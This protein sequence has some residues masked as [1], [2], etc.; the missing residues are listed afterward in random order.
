MRTGASLRRFQAM[1]AF[2]SLLAI[3]PDEARAESDDTA[4]FR[5]LLEFVCGNDPAT[6]WVWIEKLAR[7]GAVDADLDGVL[8]GFDVCPGTSTPVGRAQAIL[9]A[10]QIALTE[11]R[12]EL[13][14]LR[15]LLIVAA[16]GTLGS[17]ERYRLGETVVGLFYE[18]VS[19]GNKK[20]DGRYL[21]GGQ[22]DDV[23]PFVLSGTFGPEAHPWVTYQGDAL[24]LRLPV[25]RSGERVAISIPGARLFFGDLDGD[26]S[27]PD[28]YGIDLFD[29][30]IEAQDALHSNDVERVLLTLAIVDEAIGGQ[31]GEAQRQNNAS[32]AAIRR[33][34]PRR[35][36]TG[37]DPS[38]CEQAQ[39]CASVEVA[40]P[41]DDEICAASDFLNDEPLLREPRD[42]RV[43]RGRGAD[44]R[45]AP[46]RP[47][48]PR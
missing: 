29:P 3:G 47:T 30:L 14:M 13:I 19:I 1:L 11:V 41:Y 5:G 12:E 34:F 37:V 2:A 22:R 44:V 24:P 40:R 18:L 35:A 21:F 43:Q 25:G 8:D 45:C 28:D 23:P 20:V 6:C 27:F 33:S 42:C 15:N 48:R 38:G 4:E 31:I 9:L 26:G 39:F 46:W 32:Y 7:S 36:L 17:A 10:Q 16:N